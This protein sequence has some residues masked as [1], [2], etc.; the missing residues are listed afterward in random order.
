M[1]V[2]ISEPTSKAESAR[3]VNEIRVASASLR[4][5][6]RALQRAQVR[7][8]RAQ[9]ATAC[10]THAA[11]HGDVSLVLHEVITLYFE[12]EKKDELHKVGYSKERRVQPPIVVGLLVDRNGFPLGIGFEGNRAETRR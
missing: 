6:F 11:S 10:S 7:D 8:Y 3:V 5:M 1:L 9:A 12:A 2:R 4:T